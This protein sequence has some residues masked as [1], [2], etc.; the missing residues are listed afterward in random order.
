LEEK[1]VG[2]MSLFSRQPLT[3]QINQEMA[4]VANGIALC[5]ERKLAEVAMLDLE[6]Q[7]RHAQKLESVGQLAAGIAHDFN[8]LLTVIQGYA[9]S[10]GQRCG[11]D[12]VAAKAV[13]QIGDASQRA[14]ALTRQLLI[15]SRKQVL[16]PKVLDLNGVL[17]NLTSMLQR[18][19]GEDIAL[20]TDCPANLSRLEADAGML[21]QVVMNLA[22]NSRDAMPKGGQLLIRTS[23]AEIDQEYVRRQPDSRTGRFV[24]LTVADTGCGMDAKT[25]ERIFEPFFSTKPVGKG[26]GLGLATVYGIVTQHQGWIEVASEPNA[27]TT[28][29]IFFPAYL[30]TVEPE[31]EP[32]GRAEK[33]RGGKETILVVEDEPVLRELVGR[34]L[35]QF[36]YRVLEAG[37]GP[38]A[39]EVW[40]QQQGKI[41][42]LLTDMVMPEGLTG[43]DLA[44]QFKQCKPSL[45]V[46]YTS[47]Y[48]PDIVGEDSGRNGTVFLS[49]PYLPAQLAQAVRRSLDAPPKRAPEAVL[50]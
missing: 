29:K 10:L 40:A 45:K 41:D 12:E 35:N 22:V 6:A 33:V 46:I 17:Q 11:G 7:F 36:Q 30:K 31:V 8:N 20:Q 21:E 32:L 3:D 19:L 23:D 4:S 43:R 49:K 5:I 34:M 28:F 38:E 27:G 16:Q 25:R 1:L 26:T 2:V 50:G 37:S 9:D 24:C 18:L 15:F 44:N 39:L 13:R 47:G 14:S 48:S 42:L